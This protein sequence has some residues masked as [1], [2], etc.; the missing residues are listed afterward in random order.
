MNS[1]EQNVFMRVSGLTKVFGGTV[2][3]HDADITFYKGEIH[4]LCGENGAG[5]STLCKI[6][7]G[8]ISSTSGTISIEGT[9]HTQ[10]TPKEAKNCGIGMIYQEFNLVPELPVYENIF[11]GKEPRTCGV[12]DRKEMIRESEELFQEMH[13]KIDPCVKICDISVAYCQLVEIAKALKEQVRLLIMDEPTAPLT[14]Q[15]VEVLFHLVRR[16][17][18][19]GITIIYI[20]HRMEEIFALSD[21]LTIMRDGAVIQTMATGETNQYE[22]ISLMVGRK[23]G[24]EYPCK[25]GC[26]HEGIPALEVR[27][28]TTRAIKNVSFKLYPGEILGLAGLVGAGRTETIRTVFGVDKMISGEILVNGIPAKIKSPVNAIKLGIG[29]IPEDRKR[30]GIHLDLPIRVNMTLIT[31]KQISRWMTV[32]KRKE[33]ALLDKYIQVL[34]IKLATPELPVSSLSGGNQQKIVLAKWLATDPDIIF[35]DEPTRGIDVGAKHEIYL[36]MDRL[37][38]AGKAIVMISSELPEIIGMCDRVVVMYEGMVTGEL[39]GSEISQEAIMARASG[40]QA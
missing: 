8:A 16:L 19:R 18:E 38:R 30:Q 21:R 17:K 7:S 20:S 24:T 35:F 29:M 22:I 33:K 40:L 14:N 28:L 11:L 26:V 2:A 39:A 9:T 13:V 6:L 34:S 1:S 3:L 32:I 31:I 23:L 27:N 37:R 10:F 25:S 36:L 4:A 12:I 15:E 5:K